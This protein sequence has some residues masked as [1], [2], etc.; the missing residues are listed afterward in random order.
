ML[1]YKSVVAFSKPR[2]A[3]QEMGFTLHLYQNNVPNMLDLKKVLEDATQLWVISTNHR[4]IPPEYINVIHE[5]NKTG[6]SLYIWGDNDPYNAVANDVLNKVLPGVIL[7]SSY[8]GCQNVQFR[9]TVTSGA[10]FGEHYIFTGVANLYEGATIARFQGSNSKISYIMNSS[11][12]APAL[13]VCEHDGVAG[14][15]AVDCGFTRLFC[16]WDDAGT[17]RFV[18]NIC[19]WLCGFDLDI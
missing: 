10:G 11:E 18:K 19:G 1:E 5:F 3:L 9:S 8:Q 2:A 15:I 12:G 13:G 14:R 7:H 4:A 16:N 6:K 17:K